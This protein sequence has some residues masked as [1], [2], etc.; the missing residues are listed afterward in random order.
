MNKEKTEEIIN[1][2]ETILS[3]LKVKNFEQHYT[4]YD[5]EKIIITRHYSM[6]IDVCIKIN[7]NTVEIFNK[8]NSFN[9]D[10]FI[11]HSGK[12]EDYLESLYQKAL[13]KK[14]TNKAITYMIKDNFLPCPSEVDKIFE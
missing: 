7:G 6:A 4:R 9:S 3:W 8:T 1:K 12:W 13:E 11:Y 10:R 2:I 5:D 14:K